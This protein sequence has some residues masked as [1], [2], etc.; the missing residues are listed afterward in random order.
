M[1]IIVT[2]LPRSWTSLTMQMLVAAW[3]DVLSEGWAKW[4][5][6]NP[7]WFYEHRKALESNIN[8]WISDAEWKAV[9]VFPQKIKDLQ[10]RDWVKVIHISRD[11]HEVLLSQK[12]MFHQ[13]NYT[14]IFWSDI[15]NK[16]DLAKYLLAGKDV[17]FINYNELLTNPEPTLLEI[18]NFL[19]IDS[20]ISTM[21]SAID[22]SLYKEKIL[23]RM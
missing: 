10:D 3:I 20:D 18:K 2:W 19:W 21:K 15:K 4:N 16:D 6:N 17:L 12:Q 1:K 5:K 11:P 8:T 23:S 14:D 13:V 7:K 22:P 9:K